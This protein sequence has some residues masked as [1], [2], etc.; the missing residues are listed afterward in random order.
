MHAMGWTPPA[1]GAGDFMQ[2]VDK[3]DASVQA[4]GWDPQ[5]GQGRYR[6]GGGGT[7]QMDPAF[8]SR[9]EQIKRDVAQLKAMGINIDGMGG[10]SGP[11]RSGG[12]SGGGSDSHIFRFE[13]QP[14][15]L[16]L[17]STY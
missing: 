9:M 8:L 2:G 11:G 12:G 16:S 17:G 15:G 6:F 4:M 1:R 14:P 3:G 5:T 13:D 7:A 10:D